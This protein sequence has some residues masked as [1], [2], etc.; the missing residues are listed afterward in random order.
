[1]HNGQ[2]H[3]Y[4]HFKNLKAVWPVSKKHSEQDQWGHVFSHLSPMEWPQSEETDEL[5]ASA[6]HTGEQSHC[7]NH[8]ALYP[9]PPGHSWPVAHKKMI[10][11]NPQALP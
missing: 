7:I 9:E 11:H 3:V 2:K 10:M 4:I 5:S 8:T 1:M 6:Q